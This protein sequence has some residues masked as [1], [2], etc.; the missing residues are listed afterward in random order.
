MLTRHLGERRAEGVRMNVNFLGEA[1]LSEPEAERRLQQ[2][3]QGLQWPEIEVVSIKISTLYSQIS[4]LA[5]EHTVSVLCDRLER[6]F[7][8]A[9]RARFTRPDGTVVP[10]FVY[11]DMEE[12]RDKELTAEAFMRTLDRDG[13]GHVRAGIALQSYIPDSYRTLLELQAWARA[14]RRRGRR[15][16]HDP[17]RQGREHGERARRVLGRA[18]GRR[19]RTGPSSRRTRTTSA[20]STR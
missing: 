12:Y 14:A 20:W 11:L 2:Y 15:T 8:T 1:I 3:L 7:R 19:R 5:R 16:H 6:L 9:D 13:L 17:A 10:K 4:P 18:A